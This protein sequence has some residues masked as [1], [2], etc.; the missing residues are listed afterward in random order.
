V[1]LILYNR[2]DPAMVAR[3]DKLYRHLVTE[4]AAHGF[5]EY[6]G[7]I[8]YMDLIADTYDF[9]NGA[10]RRLNDRIKACLDPNNIIAPGRNGIG[11]RR[12]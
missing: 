3:V 12:A 2:D 6:R 11:T 9:N 7:H 8:S 1:S 5:A 4:A 10:L